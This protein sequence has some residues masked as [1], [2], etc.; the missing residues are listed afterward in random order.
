LRVISTKAQAGTK[1]PNQDVIPRKTQSDA[2]KLCPFS[3]FRVFR[4]FRA[5]RGFIGVLNTNSSLIQIQNLIV[6][7][8]NFMDTIQGELEYNLHN[9][10]SLSGD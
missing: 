9:L 4:V 1:K 8:L 3:I 6:S 2:E 5:F 7:S 10:D